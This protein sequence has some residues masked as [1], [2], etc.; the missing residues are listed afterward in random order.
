MAE[1]VTKTLEEILQ[2]NSILKLNSD[3][4][5]RLVRDRYKLPDKVRYRIPTKHEEPKKDGV[6]SEY[7]K[8]VRAYLEE[9]GYKYEY[10]RPLVVAL[11]NNTVTTYRPDFY[12]PEFKLYVEVNGMEGD[13]EA[14]KT[15]ELKKH[16]YKRNDINCS[17]IHKKD[18]ASDKWK[19]ELERLIKESKI[20][21]IK[22]KSTE[23]GWYAA[24]AAAS[25]M[26]FL[27]I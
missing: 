20:Q 24:I 4:V 5:G 25:L 16:T 27:L 10:E 17:V 13:P 11:E 14:D 9:K 6:R 23:R 26:F 2:E 7:E 15:Y 1:I 8:K 12:L 3:Q 19:S 22:Q 18:L 21:P